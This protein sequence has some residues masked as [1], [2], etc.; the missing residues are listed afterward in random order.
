MNAGIRKAHLEGIVTSASLAPNGAA[1]DDAVRLAREAPSLAIGIHLTLV[2]EAPLSDPAALP[3]LA[4]G[5]RL[6]HY[7]TTLFRR[8]LLGRIAH[9]EI[10]RE[11]TAQV[12][13]AVDAGIRVSHL[14]SHQHVHLHPTLLRSR[15]GWRAASRSPPCAR[16]ASWMRS[17]GFR[18]ALLWMFA[19][20]AAGRLRAN[21]L[22]TPRYM[23]GPRGDRRA[24]RAGPARA[25]QR[26]PG[27]QQ[28]AGVP[29]GHR[30]RRDRARLCVGFPLGRTRRGR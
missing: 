14:D 4:P 22:R 12:A 8:L 17:R 10:E 13:R 27:R 5:G 24:R 30:D 15:C 7:F 29:S 25:A 18:P 21:E 19:R 9:D 1:F 28:R 2:G 26:D 11:M 3:T 6:P 16:R 23:P 20:R